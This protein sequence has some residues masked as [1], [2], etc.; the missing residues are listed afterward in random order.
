MACCSFVVVALAVLLSSRIPFPL[1]HFALAPPDS[2]PFGQLQATAK[3]YE[4]MSNDMVIIRVSAGYRLTRP[5][6]CPRDVYSKLMIQ[7]WNANPA[8]RPTFAGLRA[9]PMLAIQ[10]DVGT[11]NAFALSIPMHRH[12]H[13]PTS[14]GGFRS[15]TSHSGGGNTGGNY[16]GSSRE[17]QPTIGG[18]DTIS[19]HRHH[20]HLGTSPYL[21]LEGASGVIIEA[22]QDL[23][24]PV[25][26]ARVSHAGIITAGDAQPLTRTL[27][28]DMP[29]LRGRSGVRGSSLRRPFL[30]LLNR[31]LAT[32]Y[33]LCRR[34]C[35]WVWIGLGHYCQLLV[36]HTCSVSYDSSGVTSLRWILPIRP[37][38]M[39]E[40]RDTTNRCLQRDAPRP[41]FTN[42]YWVR[43]M[44]NR[45][46][47]F[48]MELSECLDPDL[49]RPAATI[50][51]RPNQEFIK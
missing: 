17:T 24:S 44:H 37:I 20:P 42:R 12:T 4:T 30:F 22:D 31:L 3:P 9:L 13:T 14:S 41:K 47:P 48:F 15:N 32:W 21:S 35:Y 23:E 5:A 10:D 6:D 11:K 25:C 28:S 27:Q 8:L 45:I 7:C 33:P 43:V 40:T 49:A 36:S 1:P 19:T 51:S 29:T 26:T 46:L 16:G 34:G 38:W 39:K 18:S 50:A 2:Q